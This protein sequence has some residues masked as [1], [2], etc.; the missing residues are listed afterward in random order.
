MTEV[1]FPP[2]FFDR[3]DPGSDEAFYGFP[4]LVT[5]IDDGAI[6]AVGA[7]YEELGVDGDVLDL[8]GS[9]VSHFRPRRGTS[10][11]SA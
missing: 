6:A 7:L 8:M 3:Q 4:R 2:G 11:C 5:H 1:G 10:P 9:W